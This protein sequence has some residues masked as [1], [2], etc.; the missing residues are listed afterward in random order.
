M[1]A[2][3]S[4]ALAI[5][6]GLIVLSSYFISFELL[7]NLREALLEWGLILLAVALLVGIFNLFSVHWKK[8]ITAQ[9]GSPFSMVLIGAM[10]VTLGVAGWF[11]Q[12]HPYSLW[13]F[14]NTQFPIEASLMALLVIILA[15]AAFRL[16][17][18]RA[19][20][21]SVIFIITVVVLLLTSGPLFGLQ[22]PGLNEL[23]DWIARVPAAAGARGILLGVALGV[24]ATGLRILM[25]ADRPYRG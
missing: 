19:N 20:L 8:I 4:T 16:L 13:I 10:V 9:R 3:F 11:G 12:A 5:L 15:F 14:N 22:V 23:R 7:I 24:I 1:K 17:S 2:P 25:G 18:R 6:L 21:L